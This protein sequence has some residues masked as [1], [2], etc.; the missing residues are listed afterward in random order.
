MVMDAPL[1]LRI[2]RHAEIM[3]RHDPSEGWAERV[4]E[5]GRNRSVW[6][7]GPPGTPPDPHIHP[8]FNEWWIA[9]DG[10][11][12]WQIGQY[13]PVLS[14]WGDIIMA[15]AG[16]AHDIRPKGDLQSIRFGVTH[17]NSNHDI[18][19]VP[20]ARLIPVDE[21]Q[22][23]PNL[24]HTKLSSLIDRNGTSSNWVEAA[25]SDN[26]NYAIYT[27]EV[28]ETASGPTSHPAEDRWWVVL[29]GQ[30]EWSIDYEESVT[31]G[32]G[33]VVFIDQG[34][35][36]SMKTVGDEPSIRITIAAPEG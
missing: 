1:N 3:G 10:H 13:E 8:D 5:D 27:H 17:P 16:Y 9:L 19:G 22:T 32:A 6:I 24:I 11:T 15:P 28:P 30:I 34:K 21:G 36:Y 2:T 25:V 14:D 18:K 20:P 4:T 33:D 26:R 7:S 29:Q 31:A 23:N 12:Q 35:S